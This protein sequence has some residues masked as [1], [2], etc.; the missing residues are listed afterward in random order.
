VN[1]AQRGE[2]DP[3]GWTWPPG[4]NLTPRGELG[5]K[6]WT[7][8]PGVN[9]AQRGELDPQGWT[10]TSGVNFDPF[11][12]LCSILKQTLHSFLFFKFCFFCSRSDVTYLRR[13]FQSNW[14]NGS[15]WGLLK[16]KSN[17]GLL[18]VNLLT[19]T[20]LWQTNAENVFLYV[21][22]NFKS[23]RLFEN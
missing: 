23:S 17:I 11:S 22:E 4:V 7:W 1:L 2:L 3:Q 19:Q 5:P 12:L 16:P 20:G 8:P 14:I 9:L 18:E 15:P 21:W 10:W 6:G 13:N